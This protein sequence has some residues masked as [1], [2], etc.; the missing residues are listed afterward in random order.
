MVSAAEL[1]GLVIDF[2]DQTGLMPYIT[3]VIVIQLSLVMLKRL[4]ND[5]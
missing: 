4:F 2:L 1:I 5:G 3:A